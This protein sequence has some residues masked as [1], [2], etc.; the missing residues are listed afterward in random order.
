[1]QLINKIGI[2]DR[3]FTVRVVKK[4]IK[5]GKMK[6]SNM[7]FKQSVFFNDN[8]ELNDTGILLY[9]DALRLNREN[10][11]P[12]KLIEH[13]ADSVNDQKRI[14]EYYEF[15]KD[16]DVRELLPH[17]YFDK[18]SKGKTSVRTLKVTQ[19]LRIAAAIVIILGIGYL[20]SLLDNGNSNNKHNVISEKDSTNSGK[21]LPEEKKTTLKELAQE[22]DKS[23]S[24]KKNSSGPSL[25]NREIHSHTKAKEESPQV[26]TK[27]PPP[28][29]PSTEEVFQH[30]IAMQKV[31][32]YD[33]Q[34]ERINNNR[35]ES[36]WVM[37]PRIDDI[38]KKIVTFR[39]KNPV[40]DSIRIELF[41]K[42]TEENR[43]IYMV[44]PKDSA[45]T[46]PV[47]LSPHLYYWEVKQ[48][49]NNRRMKRVG[50][51]R[52]IIRRR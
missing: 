1:M 26:L 31:P 17:P 6:E 3:C 32:Y 5:C 27:E 10:D 25:A 19:V 20:F 39:W 33:N 13:V 16:D 48:V 40:E 36:L 18:A 43:K 49:L 28:R 8:N 22:N 2:V 44:A 34:I 37:A 9:V 30:L 23:K 46:L 42:A 45:F 7:M 4:I 11:L 15:V 14:F 12:P 35:S 47:T 51:G 41:T 24:L 21:T 50:I 52:F 29:V 38:I